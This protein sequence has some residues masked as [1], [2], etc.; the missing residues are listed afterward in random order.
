MQKVSA[1]IA[2]KLPTLELYDSASII[3]FL[4]DD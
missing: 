4:V 2:A 1:L 3:L